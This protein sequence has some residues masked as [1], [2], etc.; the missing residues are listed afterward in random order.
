MKGG[1]KSSNFK[2][3]ALQPRIDTKVLIPNCIFDSGKPI[4]QI[5]NDTDIEVNLQSDYV[6]GSAIEVDKI[7]SDNRLTNA[8]AS[9]E[10][11]SVMP[12]TKSVD[13]VF[14]NRSIRNNASIKT[15]ELGKIRNTRSFASLV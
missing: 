11:C 2:V 8:S 10:K 15:D 6:I 9:Q 14:K 13:L 7:L 12:E 3:M 5:V 1:F 4:V